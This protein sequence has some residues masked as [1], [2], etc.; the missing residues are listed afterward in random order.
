MTS[1][2]R[3]F[4]LSGTCNNYDWGKKG[5]S[6]LAARFRAQT[7]SDFAIEDDKAYS[8]LWFGDYPDFPGRVLATGETLRDYLQ[9]HRQALLGDKVVREL[10]GQLP[11]LPKV[12]Q[13]R[14]D[15]T[16]FLLVLS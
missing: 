7:N 2:D 3:V 10:D 5:R 11:F 15:Q 12:G 16:I 9:K 8:E 4:Q 1:P 14:T 13:T 6:S